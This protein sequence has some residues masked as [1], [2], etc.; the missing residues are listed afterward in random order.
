LT[1]VDLL[2]F[3]WKFTPFTPREYF[4]P[5]TKITA[6]LKEQE[7]PFRVM[8]VDKRI[9]PPNTASYFGIESIEGYDPIISSRY[10]ELMAAIA[11]GKSD[12]SPPFGFNRIVSLE[13]AGAKLVPLLGV[14]YILSLS[15]LSEPYLLPV[16]DEGET[17]VYEDTRVLPRVYLVERL[18][19]V[20][21]KAKAL[22]RL[23]G[24]SNLRLEAVVEG[25][26]EVI[27]VPLQSN[28]SSVM[29]RYES[30]VIEIDVRVAVPRFLVISN[31]YDRG[32]RARVDD[33]ETSI[34]RTNYAFQ[35]VVVPEGTHKV[36][37]SFT[38]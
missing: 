30:N 3:G 13:D 29:T 10:E 37:F 35:G 18:I 20:I 9:L 36:V 6:F 22:Q 25:K 23:Y 16:F 27:N 17:K 15:A 28:E 21:G 5:E 32:W 8:S 33:K 14:R 7:K 1:T 26:P 4:F 24:L 38:L 34:Y 31:T 11:R 19:S 12:I 2:R